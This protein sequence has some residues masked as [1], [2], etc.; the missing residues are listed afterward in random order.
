MGI[1]DNIR[2]GMINF[3]FPGAGEIYNQRLLDM[4]ERRD[5]REG[6]HKQQ[7]KP[8][9][10]KTDDNVYINFSGLVIDRSISMLF[11]KG[12]EFDLPG[13]G[14]DTPEDIYINAVWKTNK[15]PIFL[16]RWGLLASEDGTGYIKL[17][18]GGLVGQDGAEL[19]RYVLVDPKWVTMDTNPEDFEQVIRYTIR[20]NT[21][22]PDKK[23]LARKQIHR[24]DDGIA[25]WVI[26]DWQA[27]S[28]TGGKWIMTDSEVWADKSGIP[29]DFPQILHH[30]N[31]PSADSVYGMPDLTDDMIKLQDKINFVASNINKI[32]R[33]Y[34]H[35]K[36]IAYGIGA[37]QK[38]II[39]TSAGEVLLANNAEAFWKNIEMQS[40]LS[41]SANFFLTLRQTFFDIARTVDIDSVADKLGALTN[42]GLKVLYQDAVNKIET[43][44]QLYGDA[45]LELNRRLLIINGMNPDPGELIW[46]DVLPENGT[47]V[48]TELK[49]DIELGIL[50][51]QTAAGIKGYDWEQETERIQ[52]QQ[53]SEGNVGDEILR[54]FERGNVNR[55]NNE[56]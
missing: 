24:F 16:H 54:L 7:I 32:I 11:G 8:K 12:V 22:G 36:S 38:D 47:E 17:I 53:T 1:F 46:P 49:T 27:S 4:Q 42:F 6:R 51:K 34:A 14:D 19:T 18:P 37:D 35:P 20:F 2:T 44:R 5:Y 15:K 29:Y 3:L 33:L 30:Q 28:G 48:S 21:V 50:S 13:E 41:S 40:D 39:D 31:L 23:E 26:E 55:G 10:G 43:K 9:P 52:E 45:L 56:M 25:G